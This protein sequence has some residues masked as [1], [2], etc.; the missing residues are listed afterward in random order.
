MSAMIPALQELAS[1]SS[2]EYSQ[3]V[4]KPRQILCQFIDRILTDVDV[5]ALE[6]CKKTSSEPACVMLLDFVQHIIKSSS[7]MFIN[8]ACLSDHFKNSE[9]SCCDF[10]KWIISRLL[11]IAACPEC[12]DLHVKISSVIC[13]LLHL[14]RAKGSVLFGLFSTELICLMQDL[15]HMNL[16]VRPSPQWPVV[17]ERF[18]VRS[19]DP[20]VYL[21]PT[22]LNLSSYASAQ[23][24]LVTSLTVLTDILQGLFFPREVAVIWDCT[25]LML[26]HGSP[27]L[28]A[29][30]MVLLTRIVTL[31]GFPEDH[32]Q[33][34][35]SAY[36]HLLDSLPTFEE[37][38]LSVFGKEFQKLS[39]CVFQPEESTHCRFERVHVNVLMERL[40]KLVVGGAL[41]QLKALEVKATLCE[42]F[43]FVLEFVPLGYECAVQI[44]KERVTAICKALIK[45]IGTQGLQE[46]KG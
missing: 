41:E 20:A 8:P 11:R 19:G 34:F 17:V 5:V 33:P 29:A 42:V 24:L 12:E 7:L 1:A 16:M 43:C 40:E 25:C 15:V 31:G 4:R 39:Q 27:K 38:E 30:S 35:F 14:F 45:T 13:S 23:A 6:L 26:S 28:K 18:S 44:R 36:L 37:S 32:S 21:T 2:T 9:N 22:I 10:S 46:V 3:A